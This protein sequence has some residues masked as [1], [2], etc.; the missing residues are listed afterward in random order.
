MRRYD[1]GWRDQTLAVRHQHWDIPFPA[2]GM[3]LPMIEY[4]RGEPL[5]VLDYQPRNERLPTGPA[6]AAAYEA[7]GRLYRKTGEQLPFLTV[8]YDVRNWA[9]RLYP[10]NKSAVEFL[11]VQPNDP[12]GGWRRMT[13]AQFVANLYRLRGRYVPDLASF[14]VTFESSSWIGTRPAPEP[15]AEKWKGALISQRRRNYEPVAQT[16]MNWRN[17]CV[18]IDLMVVDQDRHPALF[19]DYKAPGAR[20]GLDSTNMKA[21]SDVKTVRGGQPFTVPAMVVSYETTRPEWKIRVHCLNHSARRHLAYVLGCH[22]DMDKLAKTIAGSKW[23]DLSEGQWTD[24][25]R[26]ARDL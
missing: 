3:Q 15:L 19:V 2:A 17:P 8:Q 10:H 1:T 14:G 18:D 5:A 21:I 20:I 25:L 4:D 16:R 7:L 6:V 26:C 23:V 12:D 9:F 13:E 11:D 22:D 24:V